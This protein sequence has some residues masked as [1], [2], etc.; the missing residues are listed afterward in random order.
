MGVGG[1]REGDL[2]RL[3]GERMHVVDVQPIRRGVDLQ[4]TAPFGRGG[5]DPPKIDV[6]GLPLSNQSTCRVRDDRNARIVHR[7]D[8][9]SGLQIA[10]KVEMRVDR[11]D[12]KVE[13]R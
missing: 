3:G 1:Y 12:D 4:P 13:T 9:A 8:H 10:R 5:R 6:I 7:A 2:R 11:C